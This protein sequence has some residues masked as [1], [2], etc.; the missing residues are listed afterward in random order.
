[1]GMIGSRFGFQ[2]PNDT[3]KRSAVDDEE[4]SPEAVAIKKAKQAKQDE[5]DLLKL[6]L[7]LAREQKALEEN[8][9]G[10]GMSRLQIGR[11]MVE[12]IAKLTSANV[13][14]EEAKK[15]AHGF[16]AGL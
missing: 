11:E 15:I 9:S 12:M 5:L 16:L 10:S 8:E 2:M 1:M 13:P 3:H 14:H 7:E 4:P 6:D